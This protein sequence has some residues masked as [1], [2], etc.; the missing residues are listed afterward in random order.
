MVNG[1]PGKMATE[2]AKQVIE[3]DD[4]DL[5]PYSLTGSSYG[6]LEINEAEGLPWYGSATPINLEINGED[7]AILPIP[8]N[9]RKREIEI[10][11]DQ[12]R[13]GNAPFLTVDYSLPSAVNENAE[14]YCKHG[15]PFVMGTTGGNRELLESRIRDSTISAVVAPNMAKQ[16]VAF[17]AMMQYA[18]QTFPEAFKGY[19]LEITESHQNGKADTSGTAKAMITYF[20]DLGIPFTKDQIKMIRDSEE[21]LEMG[22]PPEALTGHGWH[23]Y[24]L[25]APDGNVMFNFT[26]NV[27]GRSVYAAGTLDALRFLKQKI[28][29]GVEGKMFS[30]IDVLKRS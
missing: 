17:Q 23:T 4:F 11:L 1:L 15:L 27:N 29:V 3:S 26:H 28:E 8:S 7:L 30:M 25:R 16:I 13:R 12:F 14:L 22:I 10:I 21:Q 5:M 19:T 20:N 24:K 2:V 9:Q 18:A 6:P